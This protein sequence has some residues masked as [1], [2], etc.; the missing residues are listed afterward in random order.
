MTGRK[1]RH[2][3]Y[4]SEEHYMKRT[5]LLAVV[6][7]TFV[8][9]A[10]IQEAREL[11]DTIAAAQKEIAAAAKA[12]HLWSNTEDLLKDAQKLKEDE[13][14]KALKLAKQALAQAK[15]AQQ[16]AADNANAKPHYNN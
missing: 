15:L 13:P 1:V 2:S 10:A 7:L 9:C 12:G 11:D 4:H 3:P 8:G 16:Q 14:T 6:A 5:L